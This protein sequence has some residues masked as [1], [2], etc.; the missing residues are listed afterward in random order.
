MEHLHY[1]NLSKSERVKAVFD[2]KVGKLTKADIVAYCP[3]ISEITIERTLKELLDAGYI[4][5]VG[6][7]RATGYIKI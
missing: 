2:K 7:A 4:E 1:R 5:K 3:D 6:K